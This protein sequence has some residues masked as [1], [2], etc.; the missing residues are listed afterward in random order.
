MKGK[1]TMQSK[2]NGITK[3]DLQSLKDEIIQQFHIISEGLI[4]QIKLLTVGNSGIV[5]RVDRIENENKQEHS[6]TR[7][8]MKISF[9]Q[10]DKGFL[11]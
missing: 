6:E 9:S 1:N 11:T 2:E 3:K 7:A 4:N 10:L 5:Q 8:L